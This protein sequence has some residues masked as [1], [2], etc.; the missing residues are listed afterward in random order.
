MKEDLKV[1]HYRK[2]TLIPYVTD[3]TA[4]S[5]LTT[6]A[7]CYFV[8]D[9]TGYTYGALYNWYAASSPK[10]CP[11]GW[12]VPTDAEWAILISNCQGESQAGGILKETG[13]T[14]WTSPNVGAT[15]QFRFS[16]LPGGSHY[17][18]G[19]FYYI[20]KCGWYWST[21]SSSSTEAWH[22]YFNYN[23]VA[24]SRIAGAYNV[25]FSVRCIKDN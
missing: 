17:S 7:R 18:N 8:D 1:T 10:L 20:G 3:N 4:W 22:V 12:H 19:L 16:A 21:T 13:T 6:G 14:H 2:G 5:N 9:P 23:T 11:A 15:D 25:G 24:I